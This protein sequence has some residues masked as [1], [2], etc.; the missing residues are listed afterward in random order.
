MPRLC[1]T[2]A[3]ICSFRAVFPRMFVLPVQIKPKP[4]G[5][6]Q[7]SATGDAAT[8]I[9]RASPCTI[10]AV[11]RT[12]QHAQT[13]LKKPRLCT[14]HNAVLQQCPLPHNTR[15]K[16]STLHQTCPCGSLIHSAGSHTITAWKSTSVKTACYQP[17][18]P[19]E[20]EAL[21]PVQAL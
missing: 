16:P 15:T 7:A 19:Q 3:C 18:E 21:V 1:H 17:A 5:V 20:R 8:C 10:V 11:R 9:S 13:H 12:I 4:C 2:P 6:P 14:R